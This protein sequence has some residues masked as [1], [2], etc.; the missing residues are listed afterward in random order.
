M[1]AVPEIPRSRE[2]RR[3]ARSAPSPTAFAYSLEDATNMGAPGRTKIYEL[4]KRG[5]LK[6]IFV[7]GRT[8][9][10]GDSLRRLLGVQN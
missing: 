7:A 9:V 6:L 3:R 2:E 8:K 10:D 1:T 5:E 4:A